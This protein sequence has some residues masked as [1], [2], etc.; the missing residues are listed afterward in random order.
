MTNND[1]DAFTQGFAALIG[2]WIAMTYVKAKIYEGVG[3]NLIHTAANRRWKTWTN[4]L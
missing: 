3:R 1:P 2:L 4:K